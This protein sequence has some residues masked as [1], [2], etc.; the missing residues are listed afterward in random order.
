[1]TATYSDEHFWK[2]YMIHWFGEALIKQWEERVELTEIDT[3]K[4]K[5]KVEVYRNR[6]P[7]K[8]VLVFAHGIAGYARILLPFLMPLFEKGYH[9]V[10]PD[11]EGYG[12]NERLKGDFTWDTHLHDLKETV[13]YARSTFE[14]KLFL[15]GAS[16]GG[17]LA[18][19]TEARY[20]CADGLIC[21]CLW[22]LSDRAFIRKE[23]TTKGLT[24]PLIPLLRVLAK[25]WGRLRLKTYYT[26]SYDTLTDSPA[27]N[28]LLKKDPQAGTFI[29]LRGILS[30]ITQSKPD[31]GHQKYDK[32]ILVCQPEGDQMIPSLYSEKMFQQ[33]PSTR[34]SYCR[35]EG[36]HFPL[37]RSTYEKWADCVDRFI[38][39]QGGLGDGRPKSEDGRRETFFTKG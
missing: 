20:H 15:G 5:I 16:M 30:L 39:E 11:L 36:A 38:Q 3:A 26:I 8:P 28:N 33:I 6:E 2:N 1:M 19:A 21:W 12:Y 4:G 23:T 24:Y 22:D 34:K 25:L 13:A 27:F 32:P 7:E 31:Q 10:A 17:P 9:L 18:Y 37:D 29:S 35:F 14:G